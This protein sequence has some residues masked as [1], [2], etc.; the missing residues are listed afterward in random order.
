M[1]TLTYSKTILEK[2]SFDTELLKKEF[3]KLSKQL[4]ESERQDLKKW[5]LTRFGQIFWQII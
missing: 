2:V 3:R 4:P 5:C 1:D